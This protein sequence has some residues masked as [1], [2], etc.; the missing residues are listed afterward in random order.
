MHPLFLEVLAGIIF[1]YSWEIPLYLIPKR[2][3]LCSSLF[4]FFPYLEPQT[5][6]FIPHPYL[7]QSNQKISSISL[8]QGDLGIA[9]LKPPWYLVSLGL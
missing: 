1:V 8:S 2:S 5:K 4:K 6:L 3:L 9:S 7:P